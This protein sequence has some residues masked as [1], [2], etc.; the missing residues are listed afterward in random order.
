MYGV[1]PY[2]V[3]KVLLDTPVLIISPFVSSLITYFA[4]GLE[5][6]I[7]NFFRFFLSMTLVA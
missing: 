1:F 5:Y 6:D 3:S 2:F 4:I 7:G